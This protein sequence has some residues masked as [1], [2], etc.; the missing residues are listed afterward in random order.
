MLIANRGEIA[1]RVLRACKL[2]GLET[3]GVYSK[4]DSDSLHLKFADETICIGPSASR[5][6]YLN[7]ENIIGATEITGAQAIHPGYGFLAENEDFAKACADNDIILIGPSPEA[8]ALTGN[9]AEAKEAMANAGVP[10]I[11]GFSSVDI[12]ESTAL[13]EAEKIGFPVLLKASLGGGG[14]G[15]RVVNNK[16]EL[17]AAL[18]IVKAEA[19]AAF[20]SD[21]IY[22]EKFI[23]RARHIEIQ[24]LGDKHGNMLHLFERD[25]SIQRRNQ[26][27]VEE[28]PSPMVTPE[29]RKSMGEAAVKG[30]LSIGYTGA[31]TMEFLVDSKG[32]FYFMEFNA[33]IQV[34]HPITEMVTGVDIVSQQI[35][36]AMGEKLPFKQEDITLRGHSIEC[37]INAEDHTKEFLP[38]PG[39]IEKWNPPSGPH[40]R[41]DS[42]CYAGYRITPAYDSLLAKLIVH[43]DSR[44]E[45]IRLMRQALDEFEIE[46]VDNLIEFHKSIMMSRHFIAGDYD[47][48]S[49]EENRI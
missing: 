33:R 32:N 30:A 26:K 22:I 45:A 9:K 29:L 15:M 10:V 17:V 1:I 16:Q 14:K 41:V 38:S 39:L 37:R 48:L 8:I 7:I 49:V 47:T 24:L 43:G 44:E 12:D 11:P 13:R 27:L 25:C 23:G 28:V 36:I 18:P 20:G 19:K 46:G 21:E 35:K 4:A 40:V 31:G 42:H 34:E 6:S 2:L 3:V 5:E